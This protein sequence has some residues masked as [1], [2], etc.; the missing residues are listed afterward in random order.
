M[1]KAMQKNNQLLIFDDEELLFESITTQ[2]ARIAERAVTERGRFLFV[3]AGGET[4]RPLY[5]LLAS[6]SYKGF[7]PWQKTHLFWGDERAVPP[8]DM[9]SNYRMANEEMVQA[10][11]ISQENIH[12]IRG[13]LGA[14]AA[15]QAYATELRKMADRGLAWPRF[16]LVLLG[17]GRDG[18]TAS[19]FPGSTHPS[20]SGQAT[21]AVTGSYN[22]RSTSRVTLTPPVF[23][24]AHNVFFIVI[25]EKKAVTLQQVLEGDTSPARWPAR[26]IKPEPGNL[27]WYVDRAAASQLTES[28]R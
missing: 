26:R 16:D 28:N 25:G 20:R 6:E 8:D 12:R 22:E 18:H 9:Q 17:L 7:I 24:S 13:E 1:D 11:P 3:L 10:V 4:P 2:I 14:A 5:R 23:N 15:A 27:R 21:L 19:L